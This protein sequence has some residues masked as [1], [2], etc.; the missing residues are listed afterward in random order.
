MAVPRLHKGRGAEPAHRAPSVS[1]PLASL[2]W[3]TE[4]TADRPPVGRGRLWTRGWTYGPV[5][6]S[7]AWSLSP[8]KAA[9]RFLLLQ[10]RFSSLLAQL[11]PGPLLIN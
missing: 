7:R 3:L 4:E 11:S 9:Q 2:P 5:G 10:P 8:G 6:A 1:E